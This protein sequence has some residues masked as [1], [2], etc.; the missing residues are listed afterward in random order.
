F[1]TPI[2]PYETLITTHEQ[3]CF[4]NAEILPDNYQQCRQA[5]REISQ[6]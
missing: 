6:A 1:V 4:G 5:Y 3:L 2:Q